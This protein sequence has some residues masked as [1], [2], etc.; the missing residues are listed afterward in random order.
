M[1]TDLKLTRNVHPRILRNARVEFSFRIGDREMNTLTYTLSGEVGL[2]PL[3]FGEDLQELL[4]ESNELRGQIIFVLDIRS[5]L[6]VTSS[7]RLF[8]IKYTGQVRPTVL[9]HR[10]FVLTPGPRKWLQRVFSPFVYHSLRI[11]RK[12]APHFPEVIPQAMSIQGPHLSRWST[13]R[14]FP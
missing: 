1:H 2:L 14:P 12:F 5:S 10:R 3:Q 8:D 11:K 4:Q 7:D 13:N 6:R 9:V